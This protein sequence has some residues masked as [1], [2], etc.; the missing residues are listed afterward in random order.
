[1]TPIQ[2]LNLFCL[3]VAVLYLTIRALWGIIS[4]G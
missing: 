3:N 1:M 4:E 2:K